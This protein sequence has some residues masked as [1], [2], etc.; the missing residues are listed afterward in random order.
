MTYFYSFRALVDVAGVWSILWKVLRVNSSHLL[1]YTW[2]QRSFVFLC[3]ALV[4]GLFLHYRDD[5][6]V[7]RGLTYGSLRNSKELVCNVTDHTSLLFSGIEES[8]EEFGAAVAVTSAS[9]F[10][11]ILTWFVNCCFPTVLL[12]ILC[13]NNSNC[14][15][16]WTTVFFVCGPFSCVTIAPPH[17]FCCIAV[18]ISTIH[19]STERIPNYWEQIRIC[20][21]S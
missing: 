3:I 16:R 11:W 10:P 7:R 6:P 2:S 15:D 14:V 17:Q 18:K 9:M 4:F 8:W 13:V 19:R 21:I 12:R 20:H 1:N 5:S